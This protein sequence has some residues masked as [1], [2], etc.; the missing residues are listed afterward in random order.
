MFLHNAF[1]K[2]LNFTSKNKSSLY[3]GTCITLKRVT[4]DRAHLRGLVLG[5]HGA[6]SK[7]RR[8]GV[9]SLATLCPIQPAR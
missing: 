5:Q 8:S 6:A 9:E 7:K 4:S 1:L 2:T 3:Q